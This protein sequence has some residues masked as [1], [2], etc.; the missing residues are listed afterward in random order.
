M[1]ADFVAID[2]ECKWTVR[3]EQLLTRQKYTP[4][5]GAEF[6]GMI[7]RT[8]VRGAEVFERSRGIIGEPIGRLVRPD[9]DSAA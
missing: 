8:F 5:E 4:F 1:D 3:A 2:P 6:K 9:H 7:M